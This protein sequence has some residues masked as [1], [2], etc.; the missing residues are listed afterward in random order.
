MPTTTDRGSF[1]GRGMTES[2]APAAAIS[3]L[4][5]VGGRNRTRAS[6]TL[7]TREINGQRTADAAA[8]AVS[9]LKLVVGRKASDLRCDNYRGPHRYLSKDKRSRRFALPRRQHS[10]PIIPIIG[11]VCGYP[12]SPPPQ[13]SA[14]S[15][16]DSD[17]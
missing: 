14:V 17:Q 6:G 11:A 9:L 12:L 13:G 7:A 4:R 16:G 3:N 8:A 1:A 5:Q 10:A 15:A 2:P